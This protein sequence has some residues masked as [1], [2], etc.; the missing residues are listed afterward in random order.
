M[1]YKTS[2]ELESDQVPPLAVGA[3][4]AG[5]FVAVTL[6]EF[7]I[8][9]LKSLEFALAALPLLMLANILIC[10]LVAFVGPSSLL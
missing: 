7:V 2:P 6:V 5:L 4:A 1:T 3:Y 9:A 10:I 8:V